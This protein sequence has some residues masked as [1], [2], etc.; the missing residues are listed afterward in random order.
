MRHP[1]RKEGIIMREVVQKVYKFNELEKKVQEEVLERYRYTGVDGMYW[2]VYMLEDFGNTMYSDHLFRV[3]ED[4]VS[5][6][7]Y[8]PDAGAGFT[9]EFE[10]AQAA[11]NTALA[12]DLKGDVN[13]ASILD[14]IR[15]YGEVRVSTLSYSNTSPREWNTYI[16]LLID[17][18]PMEE[19]EKYAPFVK[20]L[21]EWKDEECSRLYTA[22]EQE[23]D[24]LTSDEYIVEQLMDEN[25]D[26]EFYANGTEY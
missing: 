18:V 4:S 11:I 12:F 9:G 8:S 7:L 19:D 17:G 26:Y 20:A 2:S 10:T 15:E 13:K 22:L 16:E 21:E 1:H 5:F 23:Y 14:E 6:S 3:D 24:Y 25:A